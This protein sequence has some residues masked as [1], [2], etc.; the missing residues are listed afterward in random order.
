MHWISPRPRTGRALRMG[1]LGLLLSVLGCASAAPKE[2]TAELWRDDLRYLARMLPAKHGNAFHRVSKD[3]LDAAVASL[4][5][6]I[7][8]LDD[9]QVAVEL[10]RIVALV[11]DGHTELWLTQPATGFHRLPVA[12]SYFGDD[13]Y[14]FAALEGNEELVGRRVTAV[15][16]VPVAEAYERVVPLI[17]RD[18]EY[19]L[20]RSALYWRVASRWD[21][22]V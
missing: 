2:M 19:E 4:H 10:G 9:P 22:S 14:V 8:V 17:A 12:L 7:P 6:R 13:L 3:E 21:G 11:G 20:L 15:G 5:A 16:G 18:N 1:L